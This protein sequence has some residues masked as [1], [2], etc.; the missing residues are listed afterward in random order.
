[1]RTWLAAALFLTGCATGGGVDEDDANDAAATADTLRSDTTEPAETSEPADTTSPPD[2]FVATDTA[3]ADTAVDT[4]PTCGP[5]QKWCGSFCASIAIDVDHC[6][7]C[8]SKCADV[9]NGTRTCAAGKCGFTCTDPFA[10]C[11]GDTA[12]STNLS[13]NAA[14][15][16]GCG[17]ACPSSATTTATCASKTCSASCKGGYVSLGGA[18]TTFGGFFESNTAGCAACNNGNPYASGACACPSGTT[19]GPAFA[20]HNDC[21]A[22]RPATLQICESTGAAAGVWGGAYQADDPVSCSLAC[23]VSNGKTGG[24][25]CPSGYSPVALRV[26]SRTSCSTIIG[27]SIHVCV[28]PSAALDNFG[29]VYE[30]DD[31]VPGN[32]GCR[33]ANPR[34]GGCSCPAGFSAGNYR[35]IVDIP[36]GGQIGSVITV[37]TR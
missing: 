36:S 1:M 26:L 33:A 11:A 23:R 31:P 34:T 25:S 28:H 2:T 5:G 37:C 20:L 29:G 4:G 10:Q 30:Q 21:A 19:A 12:C 18:C 22:V 14:H 8:G 7:D 16:G 13:N 6:G 15:C 35:S 3:T 27:S 9:V 24:C 17:K 32:L